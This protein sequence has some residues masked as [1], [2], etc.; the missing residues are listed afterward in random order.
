MAGTAVFAIYLMDAVGYSGSILV[1]LYEKFAYNADKVEG[2][3]LLG[4]FIDFTYFMS[5]LGAIMLV[6][7][8]IYFTRTQKHERGKNRR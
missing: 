6:S 7:S 2:A 8:A 3:T 5:I 1:L 4:F